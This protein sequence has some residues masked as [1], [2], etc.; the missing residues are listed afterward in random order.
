M[1]KAE[2]DFFRAMKDEN[3]IFGVLIATKLKKFSKRKQT[4]AKRK[5][6]IIMTS[7]GG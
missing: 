2:M 1:Q 3:D 7:D 6:I 4:M 5:N